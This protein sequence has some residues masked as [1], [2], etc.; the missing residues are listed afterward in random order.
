MSFKHRWSNCSFA[1]GCTPIVNFALEILLFVLERRAL[2]SWFSYL[3]N[4][5]FYCVKACSLFQWLGYGQWWLYVL[6]A[7]VNALRDALV[8]S[9]WRAPGYYLGWRWWE[10]NITI[11]ISWCPLLLPDNFQRSMVLLWRKLRSCFKIHPLT[12]WHQGPAK[13]ADK[14]L[15]SNLL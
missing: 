4:C 5:R 14:Y 9:S 11:T 6:P 15:R 1:C 13:L 2:T 7:P 10:Y 12:H 3:A 8:R